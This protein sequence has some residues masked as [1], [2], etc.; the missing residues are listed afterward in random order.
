MGPAQNDVGGHLADHFRLVHM[1][2]QAS[3]AGPSVRD[4]AGTGGC[5][6]DDEGLERG[7][8]EVGDLRETNAARLAF[9]REFHRAGNEYLALRAAALT[10]SGRVVLMAQGYLGLVNFD[11]VLEKASLGI[12]HRAAELR[13]EQPGALVAA[14]AQLG[15][16]LQG[17]DPVGMAGHDMDRREPGLQR[18]MAAMHDRA[19]GHGRLPPA[20]RALPGERLGLQQ[21]SFRAATARA[22][23]AIRPPATRQIVGA[24]RIIGKSRL[25]LG[26]GERAVMFP[27]ARH[28]GTL[29]EHAS[30]CKP[31]HH[32]MC[33]RS[34][35]EKPLTIYAIIAKV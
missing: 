18:Q 8:G 7:A 16:Q 30:P 15:L 6:R 17:G 21:P 19:C 33:H 9:G 20:G 13:Q 11:D 28:T 32:I 14:Q 31:D 3:V 12:N 5:D 23:K 24:G 34:E 22:D 35:R 2:G 25:E 27:A 10:A 29:C 1:V 4:D 26:A